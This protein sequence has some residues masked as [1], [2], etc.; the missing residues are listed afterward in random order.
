[1]A[2]MITKLH[3][4]VQD[5]ALNTHAGPPMRSLVEELLAV[6]GRER[7]ALEHLLFRLLE[8]RSLLATRETRFLHLAAEDVE[9]A[10]ERVREVELRRALLPAFDGDGT[11]RDLTRRSPS[12]LSGILADHRAALGRLAA[13]VGA[14]IEAIEEHCDEGV[15]RLRG[16]APLAVVGTHRPWNDPMQPRQHTDLLDTLDELER[17]ILLAGFEALQGASARLALPSFVAFLG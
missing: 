6:L 14:V 10:T 8:A 5:R 15:G 3:P 1:M 11:L 12:P 2:Y 13:E 4:D 17:E 9:A 16:R 7:Q